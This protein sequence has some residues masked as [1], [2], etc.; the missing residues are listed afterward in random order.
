V[1]MLSAMRDVWNKLDLITYKDYAF[2]RH[3]SLPKGKNA[4]KEVIS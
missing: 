4:Q 1:A 2:S 3:L